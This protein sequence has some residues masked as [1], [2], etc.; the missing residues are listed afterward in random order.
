MKQYSPTSDIPVA[1]EESYISTSYNELFRGTDLVDL[2]KQKKASL[3][4]SFSKVELNG[5]GWV[6]DRIIKLIFKI[7]DYRP[8]LNVNAEP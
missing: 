2:Y 4:P 5:S 3:L 1:K 6:L 7:A 8:L